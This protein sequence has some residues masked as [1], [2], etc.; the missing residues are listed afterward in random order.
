MI[1][2]VRIYTCK[3]ARAQQFVALYKEHAWPLQQK[4]L[5]RCLGWYVTVEGELNTV[6]HLW[7]YDDQGDRA[8]RREAM[9]ADPGWAAFQKKV[10]DADCVISMQNRIVR[11]TDFSPP[12]TA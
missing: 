9:A 3:P 2:D 11:P 5:G 10:A 8:R 4:Y 7:A 1:V 6:V 12:P